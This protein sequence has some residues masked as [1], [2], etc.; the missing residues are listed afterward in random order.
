MAEVNPGQP[1][2]DDRLIKVVRAVIASNRFTYLQMRSV[3]SHNMSGMDGRKSGMDRG[4]FITL[5]IY[6]YP[7]HATFKLKDYFC[8]LPIT[9]KPTIGLLIVHPI[10]VLCFGVFLLYS[11]RYIAVFCSHSLSLNCFH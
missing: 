8:S 1:E 10:F 9:L 5:S 11:C 3:G 6:H 7:N 2:L 4:E